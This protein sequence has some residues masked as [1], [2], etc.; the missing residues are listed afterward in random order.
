MA[1][2]V[3][4]GEG[5]LWARRW[6]ILWLC[7][8]DDD[9]PALRC[10]M[11]CCCNNCCT[12]CCW[13][14]IVVLESKLCEYFNMVGIALGSI[15]SGSVE[16]IDLTSSV[17]DSSNAICLCRGVFCSVV[18][19]TCLCW[20]SLRRWGDNLRVKMC[21]DDG[22]WWK[23]LWGLNDCS[24]PAGRLLCCS[25][26][27][28]CGDGDE[29][30]EEEDTDN[31][32]SSSCRCCWRSDLLACS[33]CFFSCDIPSLMIIFSRESGTRCSVSSWMHHCLY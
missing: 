28:C 11:W 7:E 29:S 21:R 13:G 12:L 27:S 4:N 31:C 23:V 26:W 33:I 2:L 15:T 17:C 22:P 3:R 9:P 20:S 1:I 18:W 14:R 8:V 10:C 32:E 30:V 6:E 25:E 19:L 24:T 16:W 5:D